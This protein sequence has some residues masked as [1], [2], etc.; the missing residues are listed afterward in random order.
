[1]KENKVTTIELTDR[2]PC[3]LC[4]SLECGVFI[5][6]PDIPVVRCC[7]CDFL[8]SSKVFSG[9]ALTAYYENDFGSQRHLQGQRV[10]AVVNALVLG[11][12]VDIQK[13]GNVL[14]VGAGYGFFLNELRLCYSLDIT[15]VE[16]SRQEATYAKAELGLNVISARLGDSGLKKGS[17]GLVTSFEVIEHIPAPVGFIQE[18]AEYVKPGGYL[19]IMTDNFDSRMARALGAS[20]PK[21]IPHSHISHFSAETLSGVLGGLANFER[22]KSLSYTP[23]EL[24]LRNGL[25]RFRGKRKTPAESFD[26]AAMLESEM[27]GTY[28]FFALRKRLNKIW[29]RLALSSN[30]DGDLIYFLYRRTA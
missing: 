13:V 28:C 22:V 18:L 12:L 4:H 11:R 21:W 19:M 8:Y 3:P 9:Q 1:M 14:D 24:M 20:Y 26:L 5:D 7:T 29:A 25:C 10:N 30:M 6:F 27:R 23:W 17:Y 15:G 2:G 16:L